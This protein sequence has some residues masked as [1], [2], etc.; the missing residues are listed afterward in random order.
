MCSDQFFL[1]NFLVLKIMACLILTLLCDNNIEIRDTEE[2]H[3]TK[4]LYVRS[5]PGQCCW[6]DGEDCSAF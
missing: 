5:V 4:M 2:Y 6:C 3:I 1:F